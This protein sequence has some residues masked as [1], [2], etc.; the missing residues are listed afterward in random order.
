VWSVTLVLA[1]L[2]AGGCSS[3]AGFFGAGER[4]GASASISASEAGDTAVTINGDGLALYLATMHA[5][6]GGD[7][8][9][10]ADAWREASEALNRSPTTTNRLRIALVLATPG[11]PWSNAADAQRLLGQLL[12]S[13]NTLLPEERIL[14]TIH[15]K[16]VEQRLMLEAEAE[17]LRAE[18]ATALALREADNARRLAAA[19]E[20]NRRLLAELDDALERLEAIATIERSI[21]ER[22]NGAD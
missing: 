21:R 2:L 22:E 18:S 5:L 11:H 19:L 3:V 8:V 6:A 15:L 9:T 12:A 1:A 4:S 17:Q 20:E 13:G 16:E 10:Q 7:P 14:A